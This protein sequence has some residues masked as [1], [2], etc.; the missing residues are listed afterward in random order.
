[1]SSIVLN[2]T[3][4][5]DKINNSTF[6]IDFERSVSLLDKHIALTSASL[7]FSWRNITTSNN[8]FSYIWIDDIEYYVE[9]PVGFYEIADITSY[10]QFVMTQNGHVM[11]NVET[12]TT[13][14]FIDVLVNNTKYSI[15]V[16]TYPVPTALPEGF[17]SSIT[18]PSVAKNPRLKLPSGMNDIFGYD[19]EFTTDA[20]SEIQTYNSTK[21]PN[22][23]PD[24]SVLLVCDQVENQFSNLGILYAIS[25]SVGIGSLIVDRPA[26]SIY[27]KLKNGSY[28]HLTFR[29]L[30][31]KTFRPIE[32]V[33]SE[34]NFIF[35]IK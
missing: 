30:S 25:P 16:I 1:M 34:I 32:I 11:T 24:S 28:N 14:Y 7:Y 19:E 3:H 18:F 23:S 2:S 31:S 10:F 12:D 21:A 33:D 9:L 4:I 27:S 17:T 20:G 35:N 13:I 22:V 6:Q 26:E 8:K 5:I 29:I 15:D